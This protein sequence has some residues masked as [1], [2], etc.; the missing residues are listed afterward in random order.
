VS[1]Q[2]EARRRVTPGLSEGTQR[3][4]GGE[5]PTVRRRFVIDGAGRGRR[6]R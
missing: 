2:E 3:E 5:E 6:G 1:V 4:S